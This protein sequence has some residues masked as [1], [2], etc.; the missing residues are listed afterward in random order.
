MADAS[1]GPLTVKIE[2]RP[3]ADPYLPIAARIALGVFGLATLGASLWIAWLL[4]VN[5]EHQFWPGMAFGGAYGVWVLW[6][7]WRERNKRRR[8]A[9]TG[10]EKT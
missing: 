1:N 6:S 2:D 4:W 10:P 9:G 5:V 3:L 7:A 8:E